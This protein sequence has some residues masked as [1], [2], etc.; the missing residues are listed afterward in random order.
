MQVAPNASTACAVSPIVPGKSTVACPV[1]TVR[2]VMRGLRVPETSGERHETE[3]AVTLNHLTFH[4][5]RDS[6]VVTTGTPGRA[7]ISRKAAAAC[8]GTTPLPHAFTCSARDSPMTGSVTWP[9]GQPI[10]HSVSSGLRRGLPPF[11]SIRTGDG[12]GR[13]SNALHSLIAGSYMPHLTFSIMSKNV[14]RPAPKESDWRAS[15]LPSSGV[16]NS[17]TDSRCGTVPLSVAP[18]EPY[19]YRQASCA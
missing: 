10:I 12:A 9:V 3:A 13:P 6:H 11:P 8:C 5:H 1:A 19:Q 4:R 7:S 15:G 18:P 17:R 2:P 14:A 16:G